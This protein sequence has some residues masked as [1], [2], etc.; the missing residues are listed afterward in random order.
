MTSK[1]LK[2]I[3][4]EGENSKV[5]FKRK[6]TT[7]EKIAKELC[8]FANTVGGMLIIGI[9]DNG[10]IIGIDSEKADYDVIEKACQFYIY[11]NLYYEIEVTN[12]SG[13][14][15]IIVFVSESRNKPHFVLTDPDNLKSEKA[16]YVRVGEQSIAAS[17]E[18]TRVLAAFNDNSP[19]LKLSIGDKEKRLFAYMELHNRVRVQDFANLVNISRRRAERLLVRLVK[20]GIIQIHI[21]SGSD[22][23]TF[24]G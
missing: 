22:Y 12:L 18:M 5:E 17:K 6:F 10:K 21:D 14:D 15:L 4:L 7:Y 1:E 2:E 19:P 23:F 20:A 24:R 8:A 11:P 16:A 13:K 9:E 3:I